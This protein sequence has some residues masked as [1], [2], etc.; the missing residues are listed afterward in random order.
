VLTAFR[1][2]LEREVQIIPKIHAAGRS[3]G[4]P[5]PAPEELAEDA[6]E[7]VEPAAEKIPELEIAHKVFGCPALAD[8]GMAGRVVLAPLGVV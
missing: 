1:R 5:D 6:G 4:R 3:P 2:V 8:A 7:V